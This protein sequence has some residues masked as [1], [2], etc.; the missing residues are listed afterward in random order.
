MC[1]CLKASSS[2]GLDE[3]RCCHEMRVVEAAEWNDNESMAA[4]LQVC[5]HLQ[6]HGATVCR[7]RDA[8]QHH[9]TYNN[10]ELG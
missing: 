7:C 9:C 5:P 4:A 8:I 1:A 10:V 2:Q 3:E 6:Q